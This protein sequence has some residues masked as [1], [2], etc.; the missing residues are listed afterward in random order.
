MSK[1]YTVKQF[2]LAMRDL[3]KIPAKA[4]PG[5]AERVRERLDEQFMNGTDPY[6]RAWASLKPAT[7]KKGRHPPPLTDSGHGSRNIT[8]LPMRGAGVKLVSKVPYMQR[9]QEGYKHT[10]ARPFFPVRVLPKL[11]GKDLDEE[12]QKTLNKEIG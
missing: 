8:A 2:T 5:F 10:E 11:W 12:I 3:V 9:H 6:G 1:R 4:S 7:L